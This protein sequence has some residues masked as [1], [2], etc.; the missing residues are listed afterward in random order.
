[1]RNKIY[2]HKSQ[3]VPIKPDGHMHWVAIGVQVAPFWQG[4]ASQSTMLEGKKSYLLE[5]VQGGEV[6]TPQNLK[7]LKL[8]YPNKSYVEINNNL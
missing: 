8:R 5:I 6:N 1:M 2:S 3:N 7:N 4:L